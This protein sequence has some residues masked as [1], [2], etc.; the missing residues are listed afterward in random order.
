MLIVCFIDDNI[1]SKA[2]VATSN[3]PNNAGGG[4]F[5]VEHDVSGEHMRWEDEVIIG[6]FDSNIK[7]TRASDKHGVQETTPVLGAA[8]GA[9]RGERLIAV[10]GEVEGTGAGSRAGAATEAGR[11]ERP[12]AVAGG[13][14]GTGAGSRAGAGTGAGAGVSKGSAA[15]A[16]RQGGGLSREAELEEIVAL[17]TTQVVAL[18]EENTA[19]RKAVTAVAAATA[20]TG[21]I[22][23]A[24]DASSHDGEVVGRGGIVEESAAMLAATA[25]GVSRGSVT[26]GTTAASAAPSLRSSTIAPSTVASLSSGVT[27]SSTHGQTPEP[28]GSARTTRSG[29]RFKVVHTGELLGPMNGPSS[30]AVLRGGGQYSIA[31]YKRLS[32]DAA[33]VEKRGSPTQLLV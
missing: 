27:T 32:E 1:H 4:G 21:V 7:I 8:T 10:A 22:S 18:A 33:V 3:D 2:A 14:E 9:G 19:L 12:K 13:G 28:S 16:G 30:G 11:G 26:S 29:V 5:I 24:S 17:L 6:G 23:I 31:A 15:I 25:A 20:A